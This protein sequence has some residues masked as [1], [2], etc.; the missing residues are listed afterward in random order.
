MLDFGFVFFFGKG[1]YF[2]NMKVGYI[3]F[4]GIVIGSV[5]I[6]YVFS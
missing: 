5:V 2:V 1:V 3:N 6:E 4:V